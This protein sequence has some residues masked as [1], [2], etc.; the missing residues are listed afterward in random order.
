MYHTDALAQSTSNGFANIV[1]NDSGTDIKEKSINAF[2]SSMINDHKALNE[3]IEANEVSNLFLVDILS[4]G[5]INFTVMEQYY[6]DQICQTDPRTG[7]ISCSDQHHFNNIS[8]ENLTNREQSLTIN[9]RQID[10]DYKGN[11]TSQH[12]LSTEN[13]ILLF[14]NDHYKN[15]SLSANKIMNYASRSAMRLVSISCDGKAKT[16]RLTKDRQA[17]FAFMPSINMPLFEN[18]LFYM[19]SNGREF[20]LGKIDLDKLPAH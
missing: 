2:R 12:I 4:C 7:I 13:A 17:D 8:F 14:Y 10:Y 11:F 20:K 19:M 3:R 5:D 6:K 18:H 16:W 1:F 9:R 15:D